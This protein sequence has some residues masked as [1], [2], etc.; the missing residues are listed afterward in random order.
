MSLGTPTLEL[1]VPLTGI[2]MTGSLGSPEITSAK[3][4]VLTA[5]NLVTG[6]VG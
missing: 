4:I 5:T 3:L 6:S 2:E 1:G